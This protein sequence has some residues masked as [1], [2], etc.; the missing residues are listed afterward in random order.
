[1][2]INYLNESDYNWDEDEIYDQRELEAYRKRIGRPKS[3]ARVWME[4]KRKDKN[5]I[6]HYDHSDYHKNVLIPE[7][8]KKID[9][10]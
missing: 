4:T 6:W 1:M 2:G 7:M 10:L 3:E 8:E 5:P 9:K